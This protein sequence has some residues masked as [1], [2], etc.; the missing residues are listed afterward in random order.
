MKGHLPPLLPI[1]MLCATAALAK[2]D[3]GAGWID[4]VPP[5]VSIQP[6]DTFHAKLFHVTISASKQPSAIW[7]FTTR[8]TREKT[9][10]LKMERYQNPLTIMDEGK[11]DVYF[12]G[13]DLAGNKS[14]LDSMRYVLDMRPPEI[15]LDPGPGKYHSKT[16]VRITANKPCRFFFNSIRATRRQGRCL[17]L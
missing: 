2:P 17:I 7:Y 13:E 9:A 4:T 12:Y 15:T 3:P 16:T 6:A 1:A 14:K 11:T 8:G 5:V 10:E